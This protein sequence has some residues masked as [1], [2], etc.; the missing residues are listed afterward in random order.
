MLCPNAV[1]GNRVLGQFHDCVLLDKECHTMETIRHE[2]SA[3]D[4]RAYKSE[5]VEF[6]SR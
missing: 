3:R 2:Q 5:V 4:S 6:L 1:I